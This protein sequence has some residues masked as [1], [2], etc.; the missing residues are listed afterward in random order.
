MALSVIWIMTGLYLSG[1]VSRSGFQQDQLLEWISFCVDTV[2]YW[3][4]GILLSALVFMSLRLMRKF[5]QRHTNE[6]GPV[7]R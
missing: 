6:A 4:S 3:G 1:F 5:L 2:E 7:P